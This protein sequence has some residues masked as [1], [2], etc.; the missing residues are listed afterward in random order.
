[1]I[2]IKLK[3]LSVNE[4]W[5]GKRFKTNKYH[6]YENDVLCLL[7]NILIAK[8]PYKINIKFGFSSILC[9]ID[10]PVKPFLDILQKKYGIN[11]K[12]IFKLNLIK[13]K[14]EKGNEY[15]EFEFI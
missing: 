5:Q 13:E 15:I 14:V 10:N 11:D 6:K 8:P 3:P 1:M 4:C 2:R 12:D 9:D 7:P